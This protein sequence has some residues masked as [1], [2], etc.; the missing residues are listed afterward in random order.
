MAEERSRPQKSQWNRDVFSTSSF[1]S[2]LVRAR[3]GRALLEPLLAGG[4]VGGWS[5]GAVEIV[6]LLEGGGRLGGFA[7]ATAVSNSRGMGSSLRFLLSRAVG[8]LGSKEGRRWMVGWK[9][10]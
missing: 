2:F 9:S 8:M 3:L 1:L 6:G 4:R 10:A 7:R 5:G